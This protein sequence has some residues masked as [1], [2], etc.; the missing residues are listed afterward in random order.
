MR[1]RNRTKGNPTRVAVAGVIGACLLAAAYQASFAGVSEGGTRGQVGILAGY[2]TGFQGLL[3]AGGDNDGSGGNSVGLFAAPVG[4]AG[5][6]GLATQLSNGNVAP[7]PAPECEERLPAL[8][9][10]EHQVSALRIYPERAE[11]ARGTFRC[12]HLEGRS[13]RDGKWYSVTRHPDARLEAE[14]AA[15]V[16]QDGVPNVFCFPLTAATPS[17]ASGSKVVGTFSPTNGAA[18]K[19]EA[20]IQLRSE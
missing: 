13:P 3:P 7:A 19:T 15:L 4:A 8:S 16:R 14:G 2:G 6:A 12:F 17:A 20:Q 1:P 10:D 5:A 9:A 11:L 18:V